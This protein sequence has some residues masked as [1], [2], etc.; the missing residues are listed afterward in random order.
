MLR[1]FRSE[2]FGHRKRI[3]NPLNRGLL[4]DPLPALVRTVRTL[5]KA[6]M[7]RVS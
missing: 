6:V 1:A 5:L 7:R 2:Y 4:S 3:T